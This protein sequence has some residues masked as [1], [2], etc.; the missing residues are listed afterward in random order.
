MVLALQ[1]LALLAVIYDIGVAI[2]VV[3]YLAWCFLKDRRD[4]YG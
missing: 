2:A 3:V 1:I 4:Y